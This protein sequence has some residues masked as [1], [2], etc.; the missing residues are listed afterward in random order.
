MK[1]LDTTIEIHGKKSHIVSEKKSYILHSKVQGDSLAL[2]HKTRQA[3][4]A[5]IDSGYGL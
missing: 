1:I 4:Q 3:R 2:N 5:R